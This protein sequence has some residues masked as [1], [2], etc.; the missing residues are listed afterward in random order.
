[1]QPSN[2]VFL[3]PKPWLKFPWSKGINFIYTI[4]PLIFF[5][6]FNMTEFLSYII[7]LINEIFILS[8]SSKK[9]YKQYTYNYLPNIFIIV[10]YI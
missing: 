6:L 2:R 8:C 4:Y 5:F 3:S 1:M 9:A 10:K 7:F